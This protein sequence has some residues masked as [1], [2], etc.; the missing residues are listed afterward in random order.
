MTAGEVKTHPWAHD[1]GPKGGP[2]AAFYHG[3]VRVFIGSSYRSMSV[4]DAKVL[5]E[6]LGAAIR[7]GEG[8]GVS[9]AGG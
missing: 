1:N 9:H 4:A 5:H 3:R 2:L 8:A 6:Q 7:V